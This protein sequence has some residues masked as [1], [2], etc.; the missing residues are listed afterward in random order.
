MLFPWLSTEHYFCTVKFNSPTEQEPPAS[1]NI[2]GWRISLIGLAVILF[3]AGLA[4]YRTYSLDVPV[5]F[6]DPLAQP[7]ERD[8]YHEKADREAAREDSIRNARQ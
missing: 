3:L 2:F 7:A 1:G 8:Y 6:D 4:A 5:G